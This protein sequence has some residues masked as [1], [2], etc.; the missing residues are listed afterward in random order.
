MLTNSANI[1]DFIGFSSVS[2][3]MDT[4][5]KD[6]ESN[7]ETGKKTESKDNIN[8]NEIPPIK[9][10][11]D[12]ILPVKSNV[13]E[14]LKK[15]KFVVPVL[16]TLLILSLIVNFIQI[17]RWIKTRRK[18]CKDPDVV[19]LKEK[20]KNFMNFDC[21]V[22][23]DTIPWK[24]YSPEGGDK[25]KQIF[26]D[27]IYGIAA[28]DKNE[29][30]EKIKEMASFKLR[31]G[32][33]LQKPDENFKRFED[34]NDLKEF[35]IKTWDDVNGIGAY[36]ELREDEADLEKKPYNNVW[37]DYFH[38]RVTLF[39]PFYS[40]S[41]HINA[42]MLLGMFCLE[43]PQLDKVAPKYIVP[44]VYCILLKEVKRGHPIKCYTW[45]LDKYRLLDRVFCDH[46]MTEEDRKRRKKV[47]EDEK[48][49]IEVHEGIHQRQRAK[50]STDN[51]NRRLETDNIRRLEEWH[52]C[53]SSSE[54]SDR[55][56]S[57]Y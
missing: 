53:K 56:K 44:E 16:A 13:D 35:K 57:D 5:G 8:F 52:A 14:P 27:I 33:I 4:G 45:D 30:A 42:G 10:N 1:V 31:D 47:D 48:A 34:V 3:L 29:V 28:D 24:F 26:D 21:P 25:L 22:V 19:A 50:S 39:S 12:E 41:E 6:T 38:K 11:A 43:D 40:C 36:R 15:N 23:T 2:V 37:E 7:M 46:I 55:L 20:L 54:L 17:Y 18:E 49:E 32:F 9:S 51:I